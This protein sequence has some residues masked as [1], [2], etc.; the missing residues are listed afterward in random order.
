ML[1]SDNGTEYLNHAFNSFLQQLGIEH[2]ISCL[3]TP[4]QNGLAERKNRTLVD[5]INS[6]LMHAKLPTNLWGEALL[7]ACHVHNRIPS[8]KFRTSPYEIWKGR[9]RI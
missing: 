8:K 3:Y 7:M 2:Q 4:Q 9:N 5:M 6:M 1:R